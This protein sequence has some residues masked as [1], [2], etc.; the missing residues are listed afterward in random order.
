MFSVIIPVLNQIKLTEQLFD[1]ILKNTLLPS[2]IFLIDNASED[3]YFDFLRKYEKLRIIYVRNEKNIMVNAAWNLGISL[4]RQRYVTIL[5]ND[6]LISSTFFDKI[7][8]AFDLDNKIGIVVP[9]TVKDI[10]YNLEDTTPVRIRE[11]TKREGWAFTIKKEILNKIDP[12]PSCLN[13]SC[14]DDYLFEWSKIKGYMNVKVMNNFIYHYGSATIV[15]NDFEKLCIIT[16][17][18]RL[19]WFEIKS[20]M[21]KVEGELA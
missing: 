8:R 12:I 15:D 3:N 13:I 11:L 21:Y 1:G 7:K 18:E 2:E 17:K 14:G 9:N 20:Q 4:A 10:N 19:D 16:K 5:N 6:I